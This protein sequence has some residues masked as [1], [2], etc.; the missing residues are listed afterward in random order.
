MA[1]ALLEEVTENA[2]LFENDQVSGSDLG[3]ITWHEP[4]ETSTGVFDITYEGTDVLGGSINST[5]ISVTGSTSYT[6]AQWFWIIAK[7]AKEVL[8]PDCSS[9]I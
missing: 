6:P 7:K 4:E 2:A 8:C 9:G 5:T 3:D 1:I